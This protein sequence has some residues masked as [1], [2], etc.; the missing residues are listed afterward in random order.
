MLIPW[1][2]FLPRL[3]TVA[4]LSYF[5]CF[6]FFTHLCAAVEILPQVCWHRWHDKVVRGANT[7]SKHAPVLTRSTPLR[8]NPLLLCKSMLPFSKTVALSSAGLCA[9]WHAQ[10]VILTPGLIKC[11]YNQGVIVYWSPLW[12]TGVLNNAIP[13]ALMQQ[14]SPFILPA[15]AAC[16][17]CWVVIW[18]GV[19]Q[20]RLISAARQP[21]F[22][23]AV[24]AD[25]LCPHSLVFFFVNK[26]VR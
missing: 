8:L 3:P 18:F 22:S 26:V 10:S 5:P 11:G 20:P 4:F 2:A 13:W 25:P 12:D 21:R 15:S 19:G 7:Y 23:W 24:P 14:W 9:A 6:I 17:C 1:Y 16:D